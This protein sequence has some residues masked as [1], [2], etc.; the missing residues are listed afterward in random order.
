M[1]EELCKKY[2]LTN[3]EFI[4]ICEK[5][6]SMLE[7]SRLTKV[8]INSFRKIAKKLGCYDINPYWNKDKNLVTDPRVSRYRFED[9]FCENSKFRAFSYRKSLI[10]I[11]GYRCEICSIDEWLG[12]KITLEIDH[13]NGINNDN[14]IENLRFLCLNCHSQTDTFRGKNITKKKIN[15]DGN[16][17]YTNDELIEVA[18]NSFSISEVCLKLKLANKGGNYKVIKSKIEKLGIELKERIE[19]EN[20]KIEK[21]RKQRSKKVNFCEC[22]K[23]IKNESKTCE[24]CYSVIQRKVKERPDYKTLIEDVKELGYCGTG[25][26]YNVSDNC[27]RKW[28]KKCRCWN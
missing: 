13:I 17:T 8:P 15:N 6:E 28:I 18:I 11:K 1:V 2:E 5:S 23:K 9:I 22:G 12:K 20:K 7:A 24:D 19:I 16:F 25:R 27:I 14:R 26:K 10:E 3:D 4:K 21:I